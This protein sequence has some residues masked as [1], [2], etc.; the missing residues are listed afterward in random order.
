MTST[1]IILTVGALLGLAAASNAQTTDQDHLRDNVLAQ[2]R[3]RELGP[4]QSGGRIVDIAVNP[5]RPQ[6]YWLASAS[7]GIWHTTNNGLSFTPQFQ[8]EHSISIGDICVAPS[9]PDVLYV[10]TGEA[11]NQRSSY[12]GD[13]VYKSTDAGKTWTHMGLDGSDHIGRIVIHPDDEK[14]AYVAAL[15]ALYTSNDQR[16]LYKTQDGGETWQR[17]HHISDKVGFVDVVLHPQRPDTVFAA[18]YER[19]RRPYT[20]HEGGAGSRLWRSEDAGKT[21]AQMSN[22]LPAG[23]LGRIGIDC[24]RKDGDVLYVAIENLNPVGQ[25]TQPATD[26]T[27][28]ERGDEQRK[29][30]ATTAGGSTRAP[31]A[32]TRRSRRR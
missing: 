4:V 1:K 6:S 16:G 13:G 25:P 28:D 17:I 10:G 18:S 8:H 20:F 30:E 31:P 11:N 29:D 22:G 9:N 19:N 3:W 15:G 32:T 2:M 5:D 27:E 12:W 21:W 14:V 7:G 24:Y 23:D 26:P